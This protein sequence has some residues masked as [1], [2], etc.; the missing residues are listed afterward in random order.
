[1]DEHN[2]ASGTVGGVIA[3]LDA[4]WEEVDRCGNGAPICVPLIGQGQSRIPELTAEIAVRLIAFSFLLRS[5]RRRFSSELRIVIH[6]SERDKIDM[7]EFQAF[8]TS[9]AN[10]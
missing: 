2:R 4:V 3:S 5:K 6:P 1:M 10:A 7:P 8:L 9:L